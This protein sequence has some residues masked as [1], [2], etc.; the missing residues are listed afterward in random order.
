MASEFELRRIIDTIEEQYR[1]LEEAY[2]Q[3]LRDYHDLERYCEK[4]E[5]GNA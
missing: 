3:L 1:G 5:Q 4:L 2:E